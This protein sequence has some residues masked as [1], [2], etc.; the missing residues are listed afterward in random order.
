MMLAWWMLFWGRAEMGPSCCYLA[1]ANG[2]SMSG[3]GT[4]VVTSHMEGIV[5]YLGMDLDFGYSW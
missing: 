3:D 1:F 5:L 2:A 4:D